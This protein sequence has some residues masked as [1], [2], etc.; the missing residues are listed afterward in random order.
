MQTRKTKII[1][2]GA[3]APDAALKQALQ[4]LFNLKTIDKDVELSNFIARNGGDLILWE[5]LHTE[6]SEVNSIRLIKLKFPEIK[7]IIINGG[8]GTKIAAE[9][10]TAGASDIFPRPFDND[11][12]IDRIIALLRIAND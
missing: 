8:S 10:L 3:D 2:Y 4:Q 11:L 12:L 1:L 6:H 9:L 7:I 5:I